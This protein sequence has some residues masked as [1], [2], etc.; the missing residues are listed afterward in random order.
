MFHFFAESTSNFN[1]NVLLYKFID[2]MN[3]SFHIYVFHFLFFI[4]LRDMH[5]LVLWLFS[6]C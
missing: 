5:L 4:Y 6:L 1:K 3:I 2:E